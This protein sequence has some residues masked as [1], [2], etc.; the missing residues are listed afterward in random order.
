MRL[1]A[2]LKNNNNLIHVID[3]KLKLFVEQNPVSFM[4][5]SKATLI[6]VTL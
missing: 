5:H 4:S 6:G 1:D 2:F 3:A